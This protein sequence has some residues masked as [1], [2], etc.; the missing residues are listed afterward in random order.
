MLINLFIYCSGTLRLQDV[1][2]LRNKES[3]TLL[4]QVEK[5]IQFDDPVNIQFTSVSKIIHI[6]FICIFSSDLSIN[7][8]ALYY[9]I[10]LALEFL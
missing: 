7:F 6:C 1:C 2:G 9:L 5:L 3:D 8:Y 4:S 10:K